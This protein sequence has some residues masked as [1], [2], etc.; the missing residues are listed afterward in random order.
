MMS[1]RRK[2]SYKECNK[3][4]SSS[5]STASSSFL[6]SF[7]SSP[8]LSKSPSTPPSTPQTSPTK[9]TYK[10]LQFTSS[11]SKIAREES[12]LIGY[13]Q[14]ISI[15]RP[16][17]MNTLV[18]SPFTLQTSPKDLVHGLLYSRHKRPLLAGS[19]TNHTPIKLTNITYTSDGKVIVNDI[20][21][22]STPQLTEY[23]FQFNPSL[24]EK[25]PEP[26]TILEILNTNKEWDVV[27]IR[28]KIIS[29]NEQRQVGSPRKPY[30]L[31]EAV[32]A[33]ESG[34]IPFDIWEDNI[35]QINL[36]KLFTRIYSF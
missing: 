28:G 2:T 10:P 27:S 19:A 35:N 26:S 16:N 9:R 22:I 34:S 12:V 6:S 32:V 7:E 25:E 30:N 14:T 18:Y 20:T 21:N 5:T 24:K 13:V 31:T 1:S 33:D 4:K 23:N 17:R 3:N 15:E 29:L 36:G 8:P 11:P